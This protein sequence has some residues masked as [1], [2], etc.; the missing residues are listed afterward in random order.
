MP[1]KKSGKVKAKDPSAITVQQ[2]KD[3]SE[4]RAV[5]R[6]AISPSFQSAL[7]LRDYNKAFGELDLMSLVADLKD[8]IGQTIDGDM[9]RAEAMLTTQAH[10]LD[11][12]F[13][14]LSRRAMQAEYLSGFDTYL[15]LGLRAQSQCRATWE[16]LVAI[17]NPIGRA[18]VGQANF[19]QNQQINN[20]T[21]PSRTRKNQKPPNELLEKT[22]GERLDT[23]APQEAVTVD[24]EL[25]TVEAKH[26]AK[27]TR[28][29]G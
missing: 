18:F 27:V 2:N 22:D 19:A 25:A 3:E 23:G 5:A 12:I 11:A 16:S 8:Q 28:G 24:P 6:T 14:N 9:Q 4:E 7:T 10:T 20:E 21:E 15:K 1:G 17:K 26:R 13:G 29:Q